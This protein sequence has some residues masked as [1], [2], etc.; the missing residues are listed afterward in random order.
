MSLAPNDDPERLKAENA[1]LRA[2][3]KTL[4]RTLEQAR[5]MLDAKGR[6]AR[7][8]RKALAEKTNGPLSPDA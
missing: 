3:C 4:E 8:A 6:A 2:Y 1:A 7:K 5:C